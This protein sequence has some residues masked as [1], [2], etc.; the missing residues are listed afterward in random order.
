MAWD[1]KR[2][3]IVLLESSRIGRCRW[4]IGERPAIVNVCMHVRGN[5]LQE[6]ADYIE[7]ESH[8]C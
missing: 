8:G 5:N 7:L 3:C 1:G 6:Q 4:E 2:I